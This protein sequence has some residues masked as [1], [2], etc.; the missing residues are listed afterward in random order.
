MSSQIPPYLPSGEAP[1]ASIVIRSMD[2]PTLTRALAC[3][4]VQTWPAIEVV[5]VNAKG[6]GHAPVGDKCGPFPVQT[7]SKGGRLS[8]S[9]AANAGI[10]AAR[11][12][13][14]CFLDDDD[15]FSPTH[16]EALAL[17]LLREPQ[18]VAA[19][20]GVSC[21]E[22]DESGEPREVMR[23]NFEF[24]AARLILENYLP[25]HAVLFQRAAA[26][27][28]AG[29]DEALPI[30]EDWDFWI[31]LSRGTRFEH[32]DQV[33]ATY[34]LGSGDSGLYGN[35][36]L[37]EEYAQR[38]LR[39]WLPEIRQ[40]DWAAIWDKTRRGFRVQDALN[41]DIKRLTAETATWQGE[42]LR[43]N[44]DLQARHVEL[45]QLGQVFATAEQA[46]RSQL[47]QQEQVR[48]AAIAALEQ[49]IEAE[50]Q[51]A[52]QAAASSAALAQGWEA[53]ARRSAQ[54]AADTLA[55]AEAA[56]LEAT[57]SAMRVGEALHR[58]MN[59][60]N[61]TAAMLREE[62][63]TV[64][65]PLMRKAKRSVKGV[66]RQLP[67]PVQKVVRQALGRPLPPMHL[68]PAA[69]VPGTGQACDWRAALAGGTPG[70][71]TVILFPVIDWHFRIQRPQHM[72]RELGRQGHRVLY[73]STT[74]VDGSGPADCRLIESPAP[75]IFLLQLALPHPVPNIYEGA[76]SVE[77][78][79][80][81][82]DTFVWLQQTADLGPLVSLI[83]LPFWRPVAARLPANL[84][85]YDCMDYHA[86]FSNNIGASLGEEH[87][88]LKT[89]DLLVTTS[90][91]LADM[92]QA[93]APG[94]P[95]ALVRNGTEVAHFANVP[96][97]LKIARDERPVVGYFGAISEWFDIQL[98]IDLAQSRPQW[99]FILVGSTFGC[100]ISQAQKVDN[101]EFVGEVPYN[102]LPGWV[103]AFDVCLIPFLINELT[104]C[105]NPVKVYE[106]LS[107][108][109]PVVATRMPELE[110]I[111]DQVQIADDAVGFARA[112]ELAFE[113]NKDPQ[114]VTARR[115]WAS[116]HSWEARAEQFSKAVADCLPRVSL[117]VLCYNNLEL[118]KACVE[119][120]EKH[121]L[122]PNLELI[123]VDNAS[124]DDTPAWLTQY[125]KGRSWVKPVLNSKNLGFAAGNNV[126]LK[127]AT[128]DYLIML[129]N[130]TEVSPG[131]IHGLRRHF[132]SD[133]GLGMV[134][135]VT[136][137]IGN[138]AKIDV[139]YTDKA[140][141]PAWAAA[142]AVHHAGERIDNRVL[143]F[144]CVALRRKVYEEV[145]GLDEAFGL[146][147]F[148]DDDYCN[149]ARAAGWR[150]AIAED[151]FVHHHLSASFD[152]LKSSTRQALF[153]KNK[154][155]YERKWGPWVPH[156]Y[157]EPKPTT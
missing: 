1:L 118:T 54:A 108:G 87:L 24:D 3:I 64:W 105:T 30:F 98:V 72:A 39:K 149:R 46:W 142:R 141:M 102:E 50:R 68:A 77:Q 153:E 89:C 53:E 59:E 133:P 130:D 84:V 154:E 129:N 5:L 44:Q 29:F 23:Y 123:L 55:Q 69:E 2:R 43:L 112:I 120:V 36:A 119:S 155:I 32:V 127:V 70:A 58:A 83:D 121:S 28:V 48:L 75:N 9:Q 103:H 51:Q 45:A 91:R 148:E 145:G 18:A 11:G 88:L 131:W 125:A 19:Y 150:L 62:Q 139:G 122:W 90:S 65:R 146:G 92:M 85:V 107:A 34:R 22:M 74:F 152:K 151:V 21:V 79:Q 14:I 115:S 140:D 35:T 73:V 38:I 95:H 20:S 80:Q 40:E 13:W 56:R 78:A 135:P 86:G 128:G 138:E 31:Q 124:S 97:E 99:R 126:G 100:D 17:R 96:S 7:V 60:Y 136:D 76:L 143:A 25:I 113:E 37:Q 8:R 132:V 49:T 117:I 61:S 16:I 52:A 26:L 57:A 137:N 66:W 156:V 82:A 111:A 47:L 4:A 116:G 104:S 110:A 67:T 106:Y 144:F 94:K 81:L 109:K 71:F 114:A 10:A 134:G 33:S 41:R 27:R 15:W 93:R 42:V 12:Q 157:R 63:F 147:F 6:E 101:I